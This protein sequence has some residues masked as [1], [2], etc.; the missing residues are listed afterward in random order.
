[1]TIEI[2]DLARDD[3]IAGFEFYEEREEGV[4]SHFLECL[5]R[6]LDALKITGGTH[7]KAHR[8]FHRA[9]SKVFPFAIYYTLDQDIVRIRAVV[10]C[11]RDPLWIEGHLEM[12]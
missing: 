4:G 12:P 11:R 5:Y 3:L 7:R 8:A 1:M 6:D 9:L 2:L 10:D